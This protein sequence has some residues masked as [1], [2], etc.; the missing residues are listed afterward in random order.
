M[1]SSDASD[2][3]DVSDDELEKAVKDAAKAKADEAYEKM[4][5]KGKEA[6]DEA[7]AKAKEAYGK[8]QKKAANKLKGILSGDDDD[9]DD[10]EE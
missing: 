10:D 7:N 8:A 5:Q 2:N 3:E 1:E 6:Y 9:D 4:K